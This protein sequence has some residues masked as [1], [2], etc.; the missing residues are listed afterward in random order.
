MRIVVGFAPGGSSEAAER[1]RQE[2][3]ALVKSEDFQ[4]EMRALGANATPSTAPEFA[5]RVKREIAEFNKVIDAR[6]IERQ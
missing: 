5:A 1:L 6:G 4:K 2:V 3:F